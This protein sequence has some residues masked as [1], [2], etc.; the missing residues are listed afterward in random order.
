M[1]GIRRMCG[2]GRV[3]GSGTMTLRVARNPTDQLTG[4]LD[5]LAGWDQDMK[6]CDIKHLFYIFIEATA[7]TPFYLFIRLARLIRVRRPALLM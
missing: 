3:V 1:I 5:G 4:L 6:T 7:R 2:M